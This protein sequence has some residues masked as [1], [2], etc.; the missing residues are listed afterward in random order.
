MP[1]RSVASSGPGALSPV[2]IAAFRPRVLCYSNHPRTIDAEEAQAASQALSG[3]GGFVSVVR[4]QRLA[5][6]DPGA[7][8]SGTFHVPAL[9]TGVTGLALCHPTS[10]K[11]VGVA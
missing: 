11:W 4:G 10:E 5:P 3:A 9:D 8:L 2:P 7:A 1:V 6:V